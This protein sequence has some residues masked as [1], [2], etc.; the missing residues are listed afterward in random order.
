MKK[1]QQGFFLLE[2]LIAILIFSLG[3]LGM[4]AM[5]GAAIAAQSDAQYRTD[6]ANLANDIISTI[7]L[8]VDRTTAATIAAS[9]DPYQHQPGGA[10]CAFNGP[11]SA[12]HGPEL[13]GQGQ[14][15]RA[16]PAGAA[17]RVCDQSADPDPDDSGRRL[18]PRQRDD[19]LAGAERQ[20]GPAVHVGQLRQ[21]R[22]AVKTTTIRPLPQALRGFSL[23]EVLV[24]V[25]IA[26][27]GVLVMFQT[28]SVWDA[29]SRSSSAGGDAQVSGALA[30]FGLERDLKEAGLGF[31]NAAMTA[32]GCNVGAAD[33]VDV[34][35]FNFPL[36][37]IE[38]IDG[39]GVGLPD[40]IHVLYGNSGFF[41]SSQKFTASTAF[42]KKASRRHGFKRGD[43]VVVAGNDAGLPGSAVCNLVQVTDDTNVDGYTIA[44]VNGNYNNFYTAT[45]VVSRFNS[46]A[47]TGATPYGAGDLFNLGPSPRFDI[48]K[49]DLATN[50]LGF[51]DRIHNTP[52]FEV[53]EGVVDMKAQYGIDTNANGQITD[54]APNEWTK[55]PPANVDWTNLRALRIAILVRSR[56]FEKPAASAAD[57]SWAASAPS[58]T[59]G[60]FVM[61]NVDGTADNNPVGSPNNWR[62]YR[63]RVYEK[64]IPLRNMIWGTMP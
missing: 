5:G 42:D 41:V 61:K 8:N 26:L 40:E 62:Y 24:G 6:A 38:I 49:V 14:D 23:I 19:L 55:T 13:G 34:R 4:V 3:V 37:P 45:A 16:G 56:N 50:T 53:A 63:Y 52:V 58:W 2:A 51:T 59:G 22:A 27:I 9:L 29:R 46:A 17:R 7:S 60:A 12:N 35:V 54:T 36:K 21:L 39:D 30:M 44:H 64:I 47:G 18:Q 25:A 20:G 48:W 43:L 33:T 11:A 28:L 57:A 10:N 32:M 15:G 1:P 31:G